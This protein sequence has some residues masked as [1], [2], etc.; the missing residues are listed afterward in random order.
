[1]LYVCLFNSWMSWDTTVLLLYNFL[2]MKFMAFFVDCLSQN[3]FLR[4]N[5]K[6]TAWIVSFIALKPQWR[7]ILAS[8][9]Y[10]MLRCC[11][12]DFFISRLLFVINSFCNFYHLIFYF[13]PTT[14][15]P[16][17][18]FGAFAVPWSYLFHIISS[19]LYK[20][21]HLYCYCPPQIYNLII[22]I[23]SWYL[24]C[25]NKVINEKYFL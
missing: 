14:I 20:S 18:H 22:F 11:E 24:I 9:R 19:L 21:E 12:Y 4:F 25:L 7:T 23:I 10:F 5:N 8:K 17:L 15:V 1:M 16:P 6:V 13:T 2:W 3:T